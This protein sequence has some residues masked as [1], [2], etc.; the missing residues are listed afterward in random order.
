MGK[1]GNSQLTIRESR[2]GFNNASRRGEVIAV[3]GG[4]VD[5]SEETVIYN[6]IAG[7]G[8][9]V[10]ACV[11]EIHIQGALLITDDPSNPQLCNYYDV[12]AR[13]KFK[14]TPISHVTSTSSYVP[15]VNAALSISILVCIL[16]FIL[17][18]IVVCIIL[19]LCGVLKHK[20]QVGS[21]VETTQVY[22]PF[23]DDNI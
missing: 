21:K 14:P 3:T 1:S 23:R 8:D 7:M 20:R 5:V 10:S 18:S 19:Y 16:M 22:V 6:N 12:S 9:V 17:Y 2:V 11:S 13:I 4:Q 15:T